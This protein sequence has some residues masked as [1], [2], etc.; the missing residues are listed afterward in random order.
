MFIDS[1]EIHFLDKKNTILLIENV[2]NSKHKVIILLMLDCG[3]RV[4]ECVSLQ[5]D[6]FDFKKKEIKVRSLKK[7]QNTEF[8]IIPISDRL[9]KALADYLYK[10]KLN[11]DSFI[12]AHASGVGHLRRESVNRFL[13]RY[14]TNLNIPNL[15]PHALR[16]TFATQHLASNTPLENIK[17]MLGHKKYDT[18]LIYTHIPTE[19]LKQNIAKVTS[20]S[21]SLLKRLYLRLFTTENK[22][23]NINNSLAN[24]PT[25]GRNVVAT[26]L[27]DL[28]DRDINTLILGDIGCG[29][30]HLLNY[31]SPEKKVLKLDD[32]DNIKKSLVYLLLFL[33]DNDKEALKVL[34][35]S[36]LPLDKIRIKLNRESIK[37]L[38]EEINKL[39][40]PKEYILMIDSLDRITPKSI[41]VLEELKDTFT[42]VAAAREIPINKTSFLW[43]FE[44]IRLKGLERKFALDLIS[45]LSYD[46]E[47]ED[48]ELF[49]NHIFEQSNGNPR[50][51]YELLD[52][53]RKEPIITNEVIREIRHYGS[54][55]EFD[56]SII[57]ILFIASLAIL[58]YIS[59]EVDNESYRFIG[60]AAMILLIISR[61]FFQTTKRKLF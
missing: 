25:V 48:Y 55:R 30:S 42:I 31:A 38:C 28:I 54:M 17:T 9:Y 8:R 5:L 2:S 23:I 20:T 11:S 34:L 14:K 26:K 29:K 58:R 50:V 13:D 36:D 39:V 27:I 33:L 61:Q 3:L 52:R 40:E 10:L 7:R 21:H 41:K 45:K 60:G 57:V 44:I 18:T 46:L 49:R 16:H 56:M 43:N 51:I 22:L 24:T 37:N 32:S 1:R 47:V 19:V 6:N 4:S 15:H 53:Y 59:R 35:F 12:F